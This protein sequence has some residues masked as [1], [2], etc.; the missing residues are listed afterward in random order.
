[1]VAIGAL[2]YGIDILTGDT[3]IPVLNPNEGSGVTTIKKFSSDLEKGSTDNWQ[4]L[5]D[6][7]NRLDQ[8]YKGL[9]GKSAFSDSYQSDLKQFNSSFEKPKTNT[10]L[11]DDLISWMY[12]KAGIPE[13]KRQPTAEEQGYF[14]LSELYQKGE[15]YIFQRDHRADF[16]NRDTTI[17]RGF[18]DI[19]TDIKDTKLIADTKAQVDLLLTEIIDPNLVGGVAENVPH[20]PEYT[21]KLNSF[22]NSDKEGLVGKILAFIKSHPDKFNANTVRSAI[23]NQQ[24]FMKQVQQKWNE[25]T[26]TKSILEGDPGGALGEMG[27]QGVKVTEQTVVDA[28]DTVLDSD[29]NPIKPFYDLLKDLWKNAGTY[30]EYVIAAIVVIALL[31][32]ANQ[33]KGIA[34]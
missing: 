22:L 29:V 15:D 25:G 16:D 31:F 6:D 34:T 11:N 17:G 30:I 9:Y 24:T 7:V 32:I 12:D 28:A 13:P 26:I 18:D 5:N 19:R 4:K 8:S 3:P 1:M 14:F 21:N 10:T 27:Y 33:I 2:K 20:T 23:T